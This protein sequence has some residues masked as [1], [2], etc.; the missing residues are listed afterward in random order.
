MPQALQG[1][2]ILD[3]SMNLPGPFLT[4]LLAC[5]GAQVLKLENP[6]GGDYGR[7][8]GGE[9]GAGPIY[10]NAVNRNK[11][12]LA[13]NL[14]DQRGQEIFFRLLKSH[15]ILV[16]GFRP[17]VMARL[18]L[19]YETLSARQPRLI[20]VSI[21]GYGQEGPYRL[22]AG[23]DINY[24]ALSGVLGMT[25][26]AS[27]GP[28]IPGVQI[29]DLAGGSLAPLAALLAA[30]IQRDASGRGQWIDSSMFD[31]LLS[32]T[33]M[34]AAG[35]EAGLDEPKPEGMTLNGRYPCYHVYATKDGRHMSL[36]ALEPKFW[37]A[38]CEAMQR[39]DLL[40][41]QFGGPETVAKISRLF[42]SQTQEHW[43]KVFK[44]H[45]ACCEPVLGL[46]EVLGSELV[47]SRGMMTS[48]EGKT[49]L[50][51]PLKL[52][53]SPLPAETPAPA[54]GQHTDEVLQD[55]GLDTDEI[56]RLQEQGVVGRDT[57]NN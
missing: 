48:L 32:L 56:T 30:I 3:L 44:D 51:C 36:G 15:D 10:F 22:R 37:Q 35:M 11:K 21:S 27:A 53:D 49:Y 41:K 54:L 4:W 33:T 5:L 13:L 12:S 55:L 8:V 40:E 9:I 23:H 57:N 1:C 7:S 42:A 46:D 20:Q 6:Q 43:I 45:D 14:K 24:L 18:G 16:E 2:K 50:A 47:R 17:G 26:S 31:G 39:P 34:V 52:P 29:A 38:F 28:V 19:D 25:G